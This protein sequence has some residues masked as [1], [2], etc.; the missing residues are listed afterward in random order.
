MSKEF[1]FDFM[2]YTELCDCDLPVLIE[3]L[4]RTT[5]DVGKIYVLIR[6]KDKQEAAE[7]L[8]NEVRTF[9]LHIV[10]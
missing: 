3:K 6:A 5:P 8:K 2:N 10:L 4:L 9:L 7:R 1:L